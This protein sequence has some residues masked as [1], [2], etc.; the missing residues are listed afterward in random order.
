[1]H[2]SQAKRLRKSGVSEEK[3]ESKVGGGNLKKLTA[4]AVRRIDADVDGD[5]DSVDMK[6][7]ETGV[8]VP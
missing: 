6:S 8:F 5:I 4:K 7:P 2:K 3:E 1:M